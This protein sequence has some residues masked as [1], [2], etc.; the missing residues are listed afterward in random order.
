MQSSVAAESAAESTVSVRHVH[1][2]RRRKFF[3]ERAAARGVCGGFMAHEFSPD[4]QLW[5]AVRHDVRFVYCFRAQPELQ[6]RGRDRIGEWNSSRL[7]E[8]VRTAAGNRAE[9]RL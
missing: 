9:H 5:V 8:G 6:S 2:G 1:A 3:A 4:H 7:P